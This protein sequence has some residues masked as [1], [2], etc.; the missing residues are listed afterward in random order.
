MR[1]DGADV[2]ISIGKPYE[3]VH[4]E[5][6]WATEGLAKELEALGLKVDLEVIGYVPGRRGLGPIEITAIYIGARVAE[7]LI[8]AIT[9]D[10]YAKT[11]EMLRAR[12]RRAKDTGKGSKNLGFTIY[13]PDGQPLAKWTTT[14]EDED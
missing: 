11:K 10:V 4:Q 12:R 14:E 6:R 9:E 5:R 3:V 1:G 8:G 7:S 13:G 2:Q